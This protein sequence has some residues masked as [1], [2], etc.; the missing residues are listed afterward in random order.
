MLGIFFLTHSSDVSAA[1]DPA[2]PKPGGIQ[3]NNPPTTEHWTIA[4]GLPSKVTR[5]A[6]SAADASRGYAVAF[7]DKQTQAIFTTSDSGTTWHQA[8]TVHG[9]VGDYVSTDPRDARDIVVLSAYAPVAG[10]YTF[11]RSLDGGQTWSSQITDLPT[12]GMIS[13]IGWAD[14]TFLVGF[15]LDGQLRGSSAVVAFPKGQSSVHLDQNGLLNGTAI[16]YLHLL[17][18]HGQRIVIWGDDGAATPKIIGAATTDLGRHW[19]PLPGTI[20]GARLMPMAASDDGTTLVAV[21][22][23][24]KQIAISHNG[25]GAW[26]AQP[27]FATAQRPQ[28]IFVAAK[29]KAVIIARGDGTYTERGGKW[30]QITSQQAAN[31]SDSGS[32]HAARLW[33][34]DAQG[35]VIW[36]DA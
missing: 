11:Q 10:R 9:P 30:S 19:T 7:V 1:N 24:A 8:G 3:T 6:F 28:G 2:P 15:Q 13:Q 16:P 22:A 31:A 32:Q 29:S 18:G 33:S 34:Y 27:T 25:G 20:L 21:S 26:A 17:T 36:L 14:S 23:D 35:R 5:L 12:T 4:Q